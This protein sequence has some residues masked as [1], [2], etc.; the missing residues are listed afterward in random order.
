LGWVGKYDSGFV[1]RFSNRLYRDWVGLGNMIQDLSGDSRIAST[2]IGLG[3]EICASP[4][5]NIT[6]SV[7]G[8][9]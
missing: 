2:E 9:G 7:M 3:W 8:T 4:E 5:K 6:L 1:G